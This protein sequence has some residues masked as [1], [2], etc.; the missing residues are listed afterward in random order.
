VTF[1]ALQQGQHAQ[2][3]L[4][5]LQGLPFPNTHEWNIFDAVSEDESYG[6]AGDFIDSGLQ[7]MAE[8]LLFLRTTDSNKSSVSLQL[9]EAGSSMF[10]F[11]IFYMVTAVNFLGM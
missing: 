8:T 9:Y 3:Q 2:S 7:G 10:H 6:G 11:E 4:P 5:P 1:S